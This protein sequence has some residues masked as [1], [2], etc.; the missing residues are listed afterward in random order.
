MRRRAIE[1]WLARLSDP[2]GIDTAW[3]APPLDD[4]A[5]DQLLHETE[6]H[7]IHRAA[8]GHLLDLARRDPAAMVAGAEPE[9]SAARRAET[10]RQRRLRDTGYAL[11]MAA[12]AREVG[13][14][15]AGLPAV[16][17]KGLDFAEAAYGDAR[18]RG[19]TDVDVLVEPA[20][21]NAAIAAVE[22][23]GFARHSR[24][25]K[26]DDFAEI[27]L[28]RHDPRLGP[29][30][31]ELHTDM[32]H[33]PELR[34]RMALT[35]QLYAGAGVTPAARLVLAALHGATSHLFGRLQY[36]VDGLMIART[37]VDAG[38]LAE[39]AAASGALLPLRTMLRLADAL[40]RCDEC[41]LLLDR[42]PKGRFGKL[43]QRLVTL[44]MVLG[45][46]A[47]GRWRRLPQRYLYRLLLTA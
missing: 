11:A 6:R 28:L 19:F 45:A 37:G 21:R 23:L 44:P 35:W 47:P 18:L 10:L 46:K 2:R 14:A 40:H 13:S 9:A 16:L 36:V 17:V 38:E 12:M 22:T 29:M 15:L 5:F 4:A 20:A 27:Q 24:P 33:A 8:F 39:R 31:V 30:L 32:V 7:N 42:L 43:E 34:R 41:R 1:A 25:G 26:G 3:K